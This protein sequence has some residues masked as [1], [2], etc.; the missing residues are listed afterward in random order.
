MNRRYKRYYLNIKFTEKATVLFLHFFQD[1][2][3]IG[4]S[5]PRARNIKPETRQASSLV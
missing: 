3:R 4:K 2:L 1:Y 5:S